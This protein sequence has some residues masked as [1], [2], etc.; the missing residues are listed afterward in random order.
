MRCPSGKCGSSNVVQL[1]AFYDEL[2]EGTAAKVKLARPAAVESRVLWAAGLAVAGLVAAVSGAV[3]GG[4]LVLLA[5]VVWGVGSQRRVEAAGA[6]RE[7]WGRLLYCRACTG[8]FLPEE[9]G[10]A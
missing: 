1:A 2:P 6:A 5:G 4:L 3:L 8:R 9:A 10:A 7:R